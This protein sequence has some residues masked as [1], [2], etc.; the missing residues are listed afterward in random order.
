MDFTFSNEDAQVLSVIG[1]VS[2]NPIQPRTISEDVLWGSN[3]G[4]DL[5]AMTYSSLS[6]R[7]RRRGGSMSARMCNFFGRRIITLVLKGR[8]C[9][10][11]PVL[12]KIR[13]F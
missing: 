5:K 4:D 11:R 8:I 7:S 3:K 13:P 10:V 12:C 1:L 9:K 2:T 6:A